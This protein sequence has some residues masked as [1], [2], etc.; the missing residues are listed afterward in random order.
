LLLTQLHVSADVIATT[1][2]QDACKG[3]DVAV[4][5]GG[6]PRKAGMERKDVMAQNVSIYKDQ[7]AALEKLAS[8]DVKVRPWTETTGVELSQARGET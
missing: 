1:S 5:V 7:A 3:V 6:F 8:R 2:V 4:M